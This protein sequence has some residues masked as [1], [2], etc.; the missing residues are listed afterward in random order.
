M[1][2]IAVIS[3]LFVLVFAMAG[4]AEQYEYKDYTVKKGDTLWDISKSELQD[5]FQWPMIWK[6]NLRINNPDL[7]YPGQVIKIPIRLIMPGERELEIPVP[8]AREMEKVPAPEP[9]AVPEEEEELISG[10][11]E[12]QEG[13]RVLNREAILEIGYISKIV[14]NE[15]EITGSAIGREV[16]GLHDEI[17]VKSTTPSKKGDRFYVIR[18]QGKVKHPVTRKYLGYQ[19]RVLGTLEVQESGTEGLKARVV[20]SFEGIVKG[21]VLDRYY[22]LAPPFTAGDPRKPQVDAVVVAL[23]YLKEISGGFDLVFIDKGRQDGLLEGDVLMTLMPGTDDKSNGFIQIV[24]MRDT[25]SLALV[26]KSEITIGEG[27]EVVG[28]R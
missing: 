26:L 23:N 8:V 28:V 19:V 22:E 18:N 12:I 7:I 6:E 10:T 14:P 16:F 5:N 24:N 21:D 9:E 13:K 1:I 15:G 20:E 11:L 2:R 25:T 4:L 17:Y 27:D 3:F